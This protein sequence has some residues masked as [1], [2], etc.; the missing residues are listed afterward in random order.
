MT[1][2]HLYLC[3]FSKKGFNTA[4]FSESGNTTVVNELFTISVNIVLLGYELILELILRML[5]GLF[6]QLVYLLCIL[7][8]I[9]LPD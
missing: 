3:Q 9:S 5:I 7:C 2:I 8:K 4:Y 1:K 6:A